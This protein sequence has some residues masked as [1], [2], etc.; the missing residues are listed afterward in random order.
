MVVANNWPNLT[1]RSVLLG[2]KYD[3]IAKYR[4]RAPGDV[5]FPALTGP[6]TPV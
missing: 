4:R 1:G 2:L 6:G 3:R 5:G